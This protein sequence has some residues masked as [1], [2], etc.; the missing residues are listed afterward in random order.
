MQK[1]TGSGWWLGKVNFIWMKDDIL[2]RVTLAALL[3]Y[4]LVVFFLVWTQVNHQE[5]ARR[6]KM[7]AWAKAA[8]K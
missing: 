5:A 7:Q 6:E 1:K 3:F 2:R 8:S 4:L